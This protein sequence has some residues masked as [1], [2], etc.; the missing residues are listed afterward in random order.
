[1]ITRSRRT[2]RAL[3]GMLAVAAVLLAGCGT[4]RPTVTFDVDGASLTAAPTQ[5]CDNRMENCSDEPNS[6]VTADVPA[7][8][9]IRIT[10]PEDVSAGPWQV[11]YAFT[12][13][14]DPTPIE[15][16]S[17]IATPGSRG[18]YTLILPSET[19]R[20]VTAQVQLFGAAPAIDPETEALEFPVRATWVLVGEQPAS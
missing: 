9:P 18:E 10:V 13:G 4:S 6:R 1:M 17:D 14:D 7:G 2:G 5:F 3:A 12:R 11:A 8:T 19:D 20:L 16:R 15:Q